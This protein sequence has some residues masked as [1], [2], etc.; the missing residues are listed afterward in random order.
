MV[1]L[2]HLDKIRVQGESTKVDSV[3][4]WIPRM[5]PVVTGESTMVDSG[6]LD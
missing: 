5:G 4:S 6:H 3:G 2:G 1:D